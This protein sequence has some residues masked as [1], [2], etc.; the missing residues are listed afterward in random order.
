MGDVLVGSQLSFEAT[1]D[2]SGTPLGDALS[3]WAE[4]VSAE[5]GDARLRLRYATSL[6]NERRYK[7]AAEQY[8]ETVKLDPNQAEA[9]SG[10]GFTLFQAENYSGAL[11]AIENA[12]KLAQPKPAQIYLRAIIQ[13]RL[14][15]YE[16]AKVSYEAF[17]AAKPAMED[18]EWKSRQRLRVIDLVLSKR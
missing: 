3:K 18:E 9:W 4:A 8:L 5:P 14:Q 11:K 16:E 1:A 17:L 10:L 15:L 2:E 7:E 6:L 12:A 13:D